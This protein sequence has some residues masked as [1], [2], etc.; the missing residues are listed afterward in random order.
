MPARAPASGFGRAPAIALAATAYLVP[1]VLSR[2]TSPTPDHPRVFLWYRLLRKPSFQPPDLAFPIAWVAIETGL[3]WAGYR[4]LRR[5]RSPRRDRALALLAGNVLGIGGWSGLFFGKRNL[6]V[7]TVASAALGIAAAAS[8]V[9]TRKVDPTAAAASVPLVLW[10]GFAT[11]LTAAI[12]R[13]N[14]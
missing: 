11:V 5:R 1:Y 3:A 4:L 8:I 6:P 14:R 9:Q 13:K 7:A 10:V 2:P 12:W